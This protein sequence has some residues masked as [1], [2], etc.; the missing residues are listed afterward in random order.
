MNV[1]LLK[2]RY[3]WHDGYGDCFHVRGKGW[4]RIVPEKLMRDVVKNKSTMVNRILC[5][6]ER[7]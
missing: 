1:V 7:V 3:R 4:A 5:E 2:I 6:G